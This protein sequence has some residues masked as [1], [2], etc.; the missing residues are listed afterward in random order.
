MG[1]TAPI[2]A[3]KQTGRVV[4]DCQVNEAGIC[5]NG[6]EPAAE[7]SSQSQEAVRQ[8]WR[9][10]INNT[11]LALGAAAFRLKINEIA[12][13]SPPGTARSAIE[14]KTVNST[15]T[16]ARIR[17]PCLSSA[18][19]LEDFATPQIAYGEVYYP[20]EKLVYINI[21]PIN[22]RLLC[23]NNSHDLMKN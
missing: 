3:E 2:G 22:T 9:D 8:L 20:S 12:V 7:N 18:Q 4:S 10:D 1:M 17:F 19:I 5:G 15:V 6:S 11:L 16:P 14:S 13:D 23:C 21:H